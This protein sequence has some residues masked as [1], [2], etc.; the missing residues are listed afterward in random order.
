MACKYADKKIVGGIYLSYPTAEGRNGGLID[1]WTGFSGLTG[2]KL[3][4]TIKVLATDEFET[5]TTWVKNHGGRVGVGLLQLYLPLTGVFRNF[6]D[7]RSVIEFGI[8]W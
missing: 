5:A 1:P 7:L 3:D 4:S 2:V 6:S 8:T